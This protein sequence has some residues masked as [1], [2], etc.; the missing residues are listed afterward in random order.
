MK[1]HQAANGIQGTVF[2]TSI[3]G[4]TLYLMLNDKKVVYS[5]PLKN[6]PFAR[7]IQPGDTVSFTARVSDTT[8]LATT[9]VAD[10][11]LPQ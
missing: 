11:K 1:Q 7:F 8:G 9:K 6:D 5:V 3:D 2:R 10:D 4:D